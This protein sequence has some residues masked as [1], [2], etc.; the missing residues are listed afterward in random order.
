MTH[1]L[2]NTGVPFRLGGQQQNAP[3]HGASRASKL[4][5]QM[6]LACHI[7]AIAIIFTG[8]GR[9][10]FAQDAGP[11]APPP[12]FEVHRISNIPHPGPPPIP[13]E[14]LIQKF[15]A[16]EDAM[17]K[18]F[19]NYDFSEAIRI[20]EL[21]NPGAKF[22]VSGEVYKKPDGQ[23]YFRP[24]NPPQSTLKVMD[25]S[26]EDVRTIASLPTFVLTSD[27][28]PNYNFQYA[29]DEK[30]DD[31][32]TYIFRV[33]P[34]Q[35]SRKRR[36]F[37][38]VVWVEDQDFIIVKSYGKFVSEL[39]GSGFKLPFKMFETYRE[40][41]QGKYWLP[42]YTVSD[43]VVQVPNADELRL[44][45][46][47]RASNFKLISESAGSNSQLAPAPSTPAANP[48]QPHN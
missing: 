47:I 32:H 31:L 1:S 4:E 46:V 3:T 23:R 20:E 48:P 45:M 9:V 8:S 40:N 13:A 37:D 11:I 5:K 14:Q 44:R 22:T 21:D 28:A 41:F 19:E 26:M 7:V 12:K 2:R 27:E 38:G 17:K 35:L 25:F 10:I 15:T 18:A 33:T 34:K 42:T 36:F 16:N 39:E 24:V 43:D 29:G 6:R 30:L